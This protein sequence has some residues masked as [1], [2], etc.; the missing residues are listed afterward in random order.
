[1]YQLVCTANREVAAVAAAKL[2]VSNIV[3]CAHSIKFGLVD[4]MVSVF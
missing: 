3:V 4:Y 1:M 2:V